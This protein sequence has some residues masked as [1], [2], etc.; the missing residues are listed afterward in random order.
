MGVHDS[1]RGA[2]G[3]GGGVCEVGVCSNHTKFRRN[4]VSAVLIKAH[5]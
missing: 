2:E 5:G 4:M 1:P 3:G